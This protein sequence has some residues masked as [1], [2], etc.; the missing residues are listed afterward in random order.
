M[1]NKLVA[2][3]EAKNSAYMRGDLINYEKYCESIRSIEEIL[4]K[5]EA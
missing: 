3:Q 2:E 5:L 1:K 4:Q